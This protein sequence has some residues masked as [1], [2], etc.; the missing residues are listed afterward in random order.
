ML[1]YPRVI[2]NDDKFIIQNA[3]EQKNEF[4]PR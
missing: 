3:D 4:Q 2:I 1:I